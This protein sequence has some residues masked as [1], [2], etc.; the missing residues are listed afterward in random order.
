MLVSGTEVGMN[1]RVLKELDDVTGRP[2]FMFEVPSNVWEVTNGLEKDL[3]SKTARTTQAA[4][5][6]WL[7]FR[8]ITK[9]SSLGSHFLACRGEK[10]DWKEP[11][12]IYQG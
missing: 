8:K 10:C 6:W 3:P 11:A 5:G 9:E 4:T 12:W 7:R 1:L 2:L